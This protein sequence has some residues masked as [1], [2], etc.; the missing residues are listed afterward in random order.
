MESATSDS[1]IA[2][3]GRFVLG[4]ARPNPFNPTTTIELAVPFGAQVS[5]RIYDARG[6]LVRTLVSG[7]REGPSWYTAVWDGKDD[8]GLS[9]SSGVYRYA[10]EA[11][12]FRES[13]SLVLLK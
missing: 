2:P 13:R 9:V 6:R 8:D 12:D 11:G 4:A 5:L 10:P 7:F 3:A 1:G